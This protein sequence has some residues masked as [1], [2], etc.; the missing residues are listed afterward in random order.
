MIKILFICHGNICRSTMA[1]AVFIELVRRR[2]LAHQFE[3]NSAATSTEA[4][5]W[6]VHR[7]TQQTLAAHGVPC[8]PH[9]ARQMTIADYRHFDIIAGMDQNNMRNM[10]RLLGGDPD[11]KLHL[12]LDFTQWPGN[13]ADPWYT[14]DFETTFQDVWAGCEGLLDACTREEKA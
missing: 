4:E 7:S 10:L 3:I 8:M 13:I 1:Q 6:P 14:G 11:G 5:G 9:T 2:G 12:L